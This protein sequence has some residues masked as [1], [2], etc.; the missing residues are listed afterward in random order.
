MANKRGNPTGFNQHRYVKTSLE[1]FEEL[2]K[3]ATPESGCIKWP[4]KTKSEYPQIKVKG[5]TQ[6]LHRM[7][8]ERTLGRP[9][10]YPKE[11]AC[12]NC[13]KKWCINPYH[14]VAGTPSY[15][16]R[17]EGINGITPEDEP[18]IKAWLEGKADSTVELNKR[19]AGYFLGFIGYNLQTFCTELKFTSQIE[20][21]KKYQKYLLTKN[22]PNTVK[23][24]IGGINSL[25]SFIQ[26][27][28]DFFK[29]LT[30]EISKETNTK[31]E[32][33]KHITEQVSQIV[34]PTH[35]SIM[36]EDEITAKKILP[37]TKLLEEAITAVS[38]LTETHQDAIATL[39]LEKLASEQR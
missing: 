13:G 1:L 36:N 16:K 33:K 8:L 9:L 20:A 34:K 3:S 37:M 12:H 32:N 39:I 2:F 26:K 4:R 18:F 11:L 25:L 10:N 29:N 38:Q 35:Q 7:A 15:N 30:K 6:L 27:N 14:L 24:K 28:P 17:P 23:R 19:E 21:V 5:K 31:P 22:Q